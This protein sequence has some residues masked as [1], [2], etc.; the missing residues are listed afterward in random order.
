MGVEGEILTAV[1]TSATM[2]SGICGPT[3]VELCQVLGPMAIV[4]LEKVRNT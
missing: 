3:L 4:T 2:A 1:T